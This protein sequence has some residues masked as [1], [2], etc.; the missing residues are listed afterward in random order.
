MKRN[1]F[2]RSL[3]VSLAF[4]C[5][6]FVQA[7]TPTWSDDI[8]CIVNSH[9]TPCHRPE[10]PGH[11]DLI[12]YADAYYWR[13]EIHAATSSRFMPPWPP[14][15][16]YNELAHARTLSQ[17]EID[18]I[19]AWVQGGAPEGDPGAT[20][21]P[22]IFNS[23]EQITDPDITA[24]MEEF[25]IPASSADLYRCFVLEI[26]NPTDRYITGMEVVPGNTAMVHHVLVFQDTTGEARA[27]DEQDIL[28][29]YTS[30]G[31][32]GVSDAKLIGA[33]VPG[34]Q[35][36]YTPQGMGIRLFA[37]ADIVIQVHYPATSSSEVD[38]TKLNLQMSDAPFLRNLAID[39]VLEHTWTLTNGPL[40]IPP[41]EV[42]SFHS[43]FEVPFPSTIVSIAPHAHL[44]CTSMRAYAV[45]PSGDTIPLIDIPNWDF[46]WQGHYQFRSPIHLP[47]GT[48]LHGEAT[49]DNTV[50][51][52]FNP[53]S[54]PGWIYLGEATTNE[55]ML[56]YFAWTLGSPAD[57]NMVI[58]DSEHMPH[59]LDCT[60]QMQVG[61]SE[62][63]SAAQ[64]SVWPSPARDV[65]YI[66]A[67]DHNGE[68]ELF[69]GLGRIVKR[70]AIQTQR[71]QLAVD[72]LSA[73]QYL[74]KFT[75][76]RGNTVRSKVVLE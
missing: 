31:G 9:C 65:L 56:F 55:M 21:P 41:N 60:P 26:D 4:S 32:I 58:D 37:N 49:Y 5:A 63:P 70:T 33:W 73:G 11:F 38:A 15:Q 69:D 66:D 39:A 53:N 68:L 6:F 10:G 45:L 62:D 19:A 8:A 40:I 75:D 42:K 18:L 20:P 12:T 71:Q 22:P 43:Q 13:N 35:A 25:V 2:L 74:L 1:P 24:T 46:R 67:G 36:F 76:R 57:E 72:D 50:N 64:L 48:M 30:F 52:P 7:Q 29:G 14:D 47:T 59:H 54:P 34:E 51:N 44:V 61:V 16:S 27:L 28:P 17:D 23:N 3:F